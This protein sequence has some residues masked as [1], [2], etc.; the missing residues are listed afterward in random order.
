VPSNLRQPARIVAFVCA[1]TNAH[2]PDASFAIRFTTCCG[3]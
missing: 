1:G 3:I 2:A